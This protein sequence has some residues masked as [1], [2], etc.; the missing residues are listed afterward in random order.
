MISKR[1]LVTILATLL[2]G[3]ACASTKVS[4]RQI[5]VDEKIPRPHRIWVYDFI[6]TPAD[7]PA[8]S[9]FAGM[10]N[11]D[12]P[13]QT[14]EEIAKGRKA[15]AEVATDLAERIRA[16]GLPAVRALPSAQPQTND[17]VI[18]GYLLSVHAGSATE[19][20]AVGFGKGAS[21]MRVAVEGFQVTDAGLR[22]LG[23][24]TVEASG[25]KGPGEALPAAM[26]VA[27]AN[28]AGLIV[29]TG[30]KLYGEESGSSKL[31]GRAKAIAKEIAEQLQPRFEAQGWIE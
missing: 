21:E 8:D 24:G 29:S 11:A 6:A 3:A 7:I 2:V 23:S 4:D 25:S 20:I 27:S 18:H 19:R 22:K 10:K 31:E 9:S 15:G 5:L 17:L 26:A 30:I 16:M 1:T 13:A 12:A 28:P 14:P